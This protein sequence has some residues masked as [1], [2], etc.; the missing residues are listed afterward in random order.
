M[1]LK[2][3]VQR[4]NWILTKSNPRKIPNYLKFQNDFQIP[5]V[6]DIIKSQYKNFHKNVN[7]QRNPFVK[8]LSCPNIPGNPTFSL[9][10]FWPRDLLRDWL[11]QCEGVSLLGDFYQVNYARLSLFCYPICLKITVVKIIMKNENKNQQ[12]VTLLSIFLIYLI[13]NYLF[14]FYF[15]N[16]RWIK[17]DYFVLRHFSILC[18]KHVLFWF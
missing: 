8:H 9:K 5:F 6:I 12:K 7:D 13:M 11:T 16:R 4:K 18:Q 15:T 17:D 2:F 1:E 14:Y 3:G 10:Q